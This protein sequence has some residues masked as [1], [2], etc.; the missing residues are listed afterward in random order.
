MEVDHDCPLSVDAL[1]KGLKKRLSPEIWS[2]FEETYV[3]ADIAETWEALFRRVAIEVVEG[4][5]YPQRLD[6][7]VTKFAKEMQEASV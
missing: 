1:G 4:N 7:R 2:Q 5:V 3:G 6:E